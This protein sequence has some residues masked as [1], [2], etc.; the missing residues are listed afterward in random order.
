[1]PATDRQLMQQATVYILDRMRREGFRDLDGHGEPTTW[2]IGNGF[3]R[4]WA[5]RVR[6][7]IPGAR[8]RSFD[9]RLHSWIELG[10]L[11]FDAECLEGVADPFD[12]PF[13]KEMGVR[14]PES[15]IDN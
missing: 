10:G 12:L 8:I 9:R 3:C 6:R 15:L 14:G 5:R 1:M 4:A 7:L 11:N 13:F 2:D